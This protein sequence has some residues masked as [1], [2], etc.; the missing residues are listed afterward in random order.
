MFH[1]VGLIRRE[2]ESYRHYFMLRYSG[3]EGIHSKSFK[4]A[5]DYSFEPHDY[6]MGNERMRRMAEDAIYSNGDKAK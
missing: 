4:E 3:C 5:H 1:L 6:E 2:A